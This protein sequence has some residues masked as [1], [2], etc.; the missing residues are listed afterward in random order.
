MFNILIKIYSILKSYTSLKINN[1]N[2][3]NI[4]YKISYVFFV[5]I[6]IQVIIVL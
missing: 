2:I 6:F 1:T 4:I 5:F 3:L